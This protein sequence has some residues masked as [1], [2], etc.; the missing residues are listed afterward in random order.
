MRSCAGGT[1][2]ITS[3][4][5]DVVGIIGPWNSGVRSRADPDRQPR[6]GRPARDDQPDQH[7]RRP[8]ARRLHRSALY[9]TAS[10]AT[11]ASSPTTAHRAPQRPPRRAPG[12]TAGGRPPSGL[13]DD[14]ARAL[15]APFDDRGAKSRA[16]DGPVRVAAP[17]ELHGARGL[18]RGG[19]AGRGLPRRADRGRTRSA[20]RGPPRRA[21]AGRHPHRSGRLRDTASIAQELG[22]GREGMLVTSTRLPPEVAAA[23]GQAIPAGARHRVAEPGSGRSRGRSGRRGAARRDRPLGRD[24]GVGGRGALRDQGQERHPRL[25]L[26]R[27]LRRHRSLRRSASTGSRAARSSP[28]TSSAPRA[29]CGP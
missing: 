1:R 13:R 9:P 23:G 4:T 26:V 3:T 16:R 14:Y 18:R 5:E 15:T 17:Q 22:T 24:T 21:P 28:T 19:T 11:P 20:G 25:V 7:V 8:D 12:R 29:A 6:G 10:A 27:P 2:R